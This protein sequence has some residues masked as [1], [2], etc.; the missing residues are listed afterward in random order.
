MAFI[1]YLIGIISGVAA[2]VQASFNGEIRQRL[3]SP[4]LTAAVNFVVALSIVAAVLLVTEHGIRLPV[5]AILE[6]PPWIWMGGVCGATI[7]MAGIL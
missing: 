6:Y 5:S 2:T 7:V 1:A 4:Y 3:R